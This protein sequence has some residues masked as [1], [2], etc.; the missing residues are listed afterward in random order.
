[1]ISDYAF[2]MNVM[3]VMYRNRYLGYY[4]YN[5]NRQFKLF[6]IID[7][8]Y[9][10]VKYCHPDR[11]YPVIHMDK[12]LSYSALTSRMY[13]IKT[14]SINKVFVKDIQNILDTMQQEMFLELL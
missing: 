2:I 1:M 12:H 11:H 7:K 4:L 9:A 3:D 5:K 8:S 13:K 10:E 6:C 14:Y